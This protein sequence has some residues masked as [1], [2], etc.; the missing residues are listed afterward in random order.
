MSGIYMDGLCPWMIPSDDWWFSVL[1]RS[2]ICN[3]RFNE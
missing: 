1:W 3:G 2:G